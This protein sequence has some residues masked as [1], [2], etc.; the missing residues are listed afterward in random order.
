MAI[1]DSSDLIHVLPTSLFYHL[2]L[3]ALSHMVS[4]RSFIFVDNDD[5]RS[6]GSYLTCSFSAHM[7]QLTCLRRFDDFPTS[8]PRGLTM[9]E[10]C[11]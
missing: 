4:N 2:Q 9:V 11:P 8:K 1:E 6:K 10:P 5:R 7:L 3:S